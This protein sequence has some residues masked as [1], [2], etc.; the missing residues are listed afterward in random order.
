MAE[1]LSKRLRNI[2]TVSDEDFFKFYNALS[3]SNTPSVS[4]GYRP[5]KIKLSTTNER[6]IIS[7]IIT[8]I[9]IDV[10]RVKLRNVLVDEDDEFLEILNTPLNDC[11]KLNTNIDQTSRA[12]FQDVVMSLLDEGCI[13]IVPIETS[14]EKKSLNIYNMRTAKIEAWMPQHVKVA[15]YNE[16]TGKIEKLT[17]SKKEV[18]I[19]ENPLYSIMNEPNSTAKRLAEKLAL[20]DA[21]DRKANSGKLDIIIQLP[22]VVK[23]EKRLEEAK[24]RIEN[25]QTQLQNS[26]YGIAYA[27]ATEK[28]TQLNRPA[29]NTLQTQIEYLTR[30]LY[31]QLGIT[32]TVFDGTA[33]EKTMLHY[34]NRS[35]VPILDSICESMIRSFISEDDLK[36][37]I[38]IKYFRDLFASVPVTE[39]ATAAD[40]LTRNAIMKSN[41][42]RAKLNLRPSDEPIANELSNKNISSGNQKPREG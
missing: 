7:S 25:L 38:S 36:A 39:I 29:E 9:A 20:L 11:L 15:V 3:V 32:Q 18:A 31:D 19:I 33:D 30:M 37:G 17:L 23:S 16:Q 22:Y 1:K 4:Y 28:I 35:I 2:F 42:I 26:Q 21:A 27:D 24:N 34:H 5:D 10:A 40:S 14:F 41:E 12:F 13:A 6:T 8:R